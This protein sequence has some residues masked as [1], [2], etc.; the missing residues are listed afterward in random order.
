MKQWAKQFYNSDAWR[1]CRETFLQSRGYLCERCSTLDN[2]IIAKIAHH[3][4][5]LTQR[6]INDPGTSLCYDNLEALCQDCHNKEHHRAAREAR[7]IMDANGILHPP[8]H[9]DKSALENTE[10]AV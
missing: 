6:N 7:Y 9:G 5:W 8:I 4:T 3:R 1:Q 10:C 2:P